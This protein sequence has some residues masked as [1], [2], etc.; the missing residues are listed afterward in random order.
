MFRAPC[1]VV[2]LL[3]GGLVAGC[4]DSEPEVGPGDRG[5]ETPSPGENSPGTTTTAD[6][7]TNLIGR[8][9]TVVATI[10]DGATQRLAV[11]TARPW[12]TVGDDGLSGLFTGCN[13]GRTVVRIEG[14]TISFGKTRVTRGACEGPARLTEEAVL[15]VLEGASDDVTLNGK[16][17]VVEKGDTGLVFQVR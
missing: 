3:A 13:S 4:S 11:R 10:A 14:N 17:L 6:D 16:V 8:T 9:W 5:T 7:L 15:D 2:V 12:I 1:A